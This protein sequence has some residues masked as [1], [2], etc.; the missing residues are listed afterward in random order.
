MLVCRLCLALLVVNEQEK[1]EGS[2]D[3]LAACLNAVHS[4]SQDAIRNIINSLKTLR[5]AANKESNTELR[6]LLWNCVELMEVFLRSYEDTGLLARTYHA[7]EEVYSAMVEYSSMR[8]YVFGAL[9]VIV[10][11]ALYRYSC[12][13]LKK[14]KTE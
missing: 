13:S 12:S 2:I 9:S 6:K 5:I 11:Q 1:L 14:K 8:Q 10:L 3:N 4:N 7:R